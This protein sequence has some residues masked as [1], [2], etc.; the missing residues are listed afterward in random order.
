[1]IIIDNG[2]LVAEGTS[3][4]L[5]RKY[6]GDFLIEVLIDGLPSDQGEEWLHKIIQLPVEKVSQPLNGAPRTAWIRSTAGHSDLPLVISRLSERGVTVKQASMREPSLGDV[7]LT[8]TGSQLR[9]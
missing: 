2:K 5:K 7:F 8:I 6:I 1:M 9:D 3:S 4:E